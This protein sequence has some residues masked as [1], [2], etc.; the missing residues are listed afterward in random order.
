VEELSFFPDPRSNVSVPDQKAAY[1]KT[2]M[3]KSL[4]ALIVKCAD[5]I[6]NTIDFM[7]GAPDY[8]GKYWRKAEPLFEAMMSRGEQILEFGPDVL[9]RMKWSRDSLKRQLVR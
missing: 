9:P 5:R 7:T 4:R 8:A 2:F 3:T 6:C 1:M